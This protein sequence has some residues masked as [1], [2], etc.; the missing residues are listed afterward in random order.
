MRTSHRATETE[1]KEDGSSLPG[2]AAAGAVAGEVPS[3]ACGGVSLPIVLPLLPD[4][5][6]YCPLP[7]LAGGAHPPRPWRWRWRRRRRRRNASADVYGEPAE[8]E[9]GG[10][11]D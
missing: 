5:P 2:L 11:A 1:E 7:R 4:W 10:E 8:G 9:D 3:V 6:S